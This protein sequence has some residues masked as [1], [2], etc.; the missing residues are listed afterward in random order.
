MV[1]GLLASRILLLFWFYL[2]NYD[3]T[4]RADLVVDWGLDFFIDRY[5]KAPVEFWLTPGASF[6][7]IYGL[8]IG[9]FII[10]KYYFF[11]SALVSSLLVAYTAHFF[12]L[13]GL[14]VFAVI[15]AGTYVFMLVTWIDAV[16]PWIESNVTKVRSFRSDITQLYNSRTIRFAVGSSILVIW[17]IFISHAIEKGY[18]L[19]EPQFLHKRVLDIRL[20]EYGLLICSI[21]ILLIILKPSIVSAGWN[22]TIS[23]FIFLTPLSIIGIQFLRQI[24]IP[25]IEGSLS[26]KIVLL[27]I[28]LGFSALVSQIKLHRLVSW[29]SSIQTLLIKKRLLRTRLAKRE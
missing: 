6:L 29:I 20:I 23:K 24:F 11:A 1:V 12:T 22:K 5:N 4:S 7:L 2:F 13:D 26:L 16:Y 27:V 19:N 17:F 15:I 8:S 14:R 10:N 21:V 9:Y 3:L 25:G 28:A 18:F